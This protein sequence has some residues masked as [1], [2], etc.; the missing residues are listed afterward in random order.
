MSMRSG[1]EKL[2][3][4]FQA[5]GSSPAA[6]CS[7]E[8]LDRIWR[9]VAGELPAEERREL[10]ERMA[11]DPACAEAWRVAQ[12]LWRA[13]NG[14]A[15]TTG[16]ETRGRSWHPSWLA[17]AAVLVLAVGAVVLMRVNAP[18]ADEFRDPAGYA[19]E[20]LVAPDAS[21]PRGAFRL[22]WAAAPAGARY[23]VRMTTED[24]RVLATARGLTTPEL[25]VD[26]DRLSG[27][28]SGTRV[29]WQV[30]VTLPGGERVTSP[31]FTARVE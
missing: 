20:S 6:G 13:A 14:E 19:V 18:P 22:R 26:P 23:D 30:D 17:A 24:L 21:L 3:E 10:V 29:L 4:A 2:K 7:D 16:V 25:V 27:V 31:T 5:L 15:D 9:A 28:A 8:E 12:E 11:V 1:D